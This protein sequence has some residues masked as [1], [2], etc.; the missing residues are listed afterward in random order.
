MTGLG[1]YSVNPV[2]PVPQPVA[3]PPGVLAA[4][5]LVQVVTILAADAE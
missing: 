3:A 1:V 5:C 2:G 4:P